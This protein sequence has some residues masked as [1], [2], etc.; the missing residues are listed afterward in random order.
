MS[1]VETKPFDS[2]QGDNIISIKKGD[3]TKNAITFKIIN[4]YQI[5][6]L[7]MIKHF[8]KLSVTIQ[9]DKNKTYACPVGPKFNGIGGCSS[10]LICPCI[11]SN[12]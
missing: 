3:Y 1:G 9:Y 7:L 6:I 2:A 11:L 4:F 10:S 12:L 5:S 8:D